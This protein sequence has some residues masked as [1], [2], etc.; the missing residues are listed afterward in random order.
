MLTS[1]KRMKRGNGATEAPSIVV[2]G[3][4]SSEK[5]VESEKK[6]SVIIIMFNCFDLYKFHLEFCHNASSHSLSPRRA[7]IE[8]VFAIL[9]HTVSN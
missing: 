8:C 6:N 2:D 4:I 3:K 9:C 5:C 7:G 1:I